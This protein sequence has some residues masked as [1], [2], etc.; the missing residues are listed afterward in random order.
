MS[1]N[2]SI[3]AGLSKIRNAEKVS[4]VLCTIKPISKVLKQVLDILKEKRYLGEYEVIIDGK[5]DHIRV[6]L[7]GAINKCGVIKPRYAVTIDDY[8][9]FEKRYL[10]S[11]NMGIL[12]VS[13]SQGLMIHRQAKEKALGGRLIAYCY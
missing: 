1:M 2:D 3:A 13:T 6:N 7:I 10:P 11:R 8:E 4:K 5:G 9:K 12:I